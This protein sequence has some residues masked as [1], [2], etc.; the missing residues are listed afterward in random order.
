MSVC[1]HRP[2]SRMRDTVTIM[3]KFDS[4]TPVYFNKYYFVLVYFDVIRVKYLINA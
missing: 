3:F 1:S 2:M 4:F